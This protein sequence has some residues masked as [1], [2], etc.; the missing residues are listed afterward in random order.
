M[1]LG[2]TMLRSEH[3]AALAAIQQRYDARTDL[4]RTQARADNRYYLWCGLGAGAIIGASA[5]LLVVVA[6]V[7]WPK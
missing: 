3:T 5:A 6:C 1:P 7:L 2:D 4:A